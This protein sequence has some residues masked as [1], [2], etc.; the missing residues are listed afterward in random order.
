MKEMAREKCE[1]MNKAKKITFPYIFVLRLKTIQKKAL[2][3]ANSPSGGH[4][5][6]KTKRSATVRA[7]TLQP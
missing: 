3:Q 2:L 7:R 4:L 6:L 1:Q 5:T